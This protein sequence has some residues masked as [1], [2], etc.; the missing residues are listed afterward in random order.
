MFFAGVLFVLFEAA[1]FLTL[2]LIVFFS[3][4]K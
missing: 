1:A 3:L 2:P 4:K